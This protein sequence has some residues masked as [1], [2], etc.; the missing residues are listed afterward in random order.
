MFYKFYKKNGLYGD[1][2]ARIMEDKKENLWF[3][4]DGLSRYDG[5]SFTCFTTK[6]GLINHAI[7]VILEIELE[8]FGLVREQQVSTFTME[9]LLPVFSE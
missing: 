7:L 5:K 1:I 3:G 9:K 4:G 6:E 8:I 2:V